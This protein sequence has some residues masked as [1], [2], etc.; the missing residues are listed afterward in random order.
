MNEHSGWG[1]CPVEGASP[2]DCVTL[3]HG[4]GG[5]LSRRLLRD[6]VLPRLQNDTLIRMEDSATL[7][8]A[9]M[10]S[11]AASPGSAGS[12][13]F[14]T[15]G[16]T[17]S[18]LFFPGGDI[19]QLAVYGTVND[20]AVSG[21]R[22]KWLSL[23]LIIEEGL[24]LSTLDRILDSVRDAARIADV[25]VVTGD[26]KVVPRGAV[27]QIFVTTSGIG[28]V[29]DIP[30]AG[31]ARLQ[32]GDAI[33][34]S[35]PV[36]R[37]GASIL[38]SREQFG[39]EPAPASDCAPLIEPLMALMTDK[40]SP[41]AARDA[42]R[43][44]VAAVLHEWTE[45]SSTSCL[46]QEALIPITSPV[47]AVC[48][49]LGMD[50]LFLACE[51]AFVLATAPDKVSQTLETLRQFEVTRNATLIGHLRNARRT[52]VSIERVSGREVPLDEP[53]GGQLPRIC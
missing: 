41:K 4:E 33:L 40:L 36:G 53:A 35:G 26:T 7:P 5:R 18:P 9:E 14:T 31:A 27:D 25:Q 32:P 34:V 50:P 49:L 10:G 46:I 1:S 42:T 44:G 19:G 24:P 17:V 45:E 37:H 48:E 11:G 8:V 20:L 3:S 13:A 30:P 38:C 43:G 28:L 21:A 29:M 22:A 39:F 15:D 47:R 52:R 23:S 2:L 6:H 51:G 12:I 16:Y